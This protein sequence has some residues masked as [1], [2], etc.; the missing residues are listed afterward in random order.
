MGGYYA[1]K[2]AGR[3][4]LRCYDLAPPRV[5]RSLEAE[6]TFV[7]EHVSPGD[8]VLELGC[9]YGRVLGRLVG[10]ARLT[11]GID[12]STES[13]DLAR[14]HLGDDPALRLQEMDAI[15]MKFGD[16]E[17]DVVICIQNGICAFGVDQ[18]ALL[19]EALRVAR[20]GGTV[21]L[22]SYSPRFWA[23]R[24]DWFRRQADEGLIG[25][26][27]E[28]A[29]GDGVIVCA[30]GLRL[31]AVGPDDFAALLRECDV[32]GRISEVDGSSIFCVIKKP[33]Q[34]PIS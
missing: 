8:S 7:L 24:L 28:Q 15:E 14:R 12:T 1:E 16:R 21:L 33:G 3:R 20:P 25:P 23:D 9:G 6:I 30:D 19:H 31:G 32:E 10:R 17:F 18:A 29:T 26:L 4:L 2:L 34:L 22:S 13:L 5:R 27:D 11:T